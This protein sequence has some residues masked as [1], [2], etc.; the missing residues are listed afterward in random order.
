MKFHPTKKSY[1]TEALRANKNFLNGIAS[2]K[3]TIETASV[4]QIIPFWNNLFWPLKHVVQGWE[5]RI[6]C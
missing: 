1:A 6:C 3:G 2:K 5:I 4:Y